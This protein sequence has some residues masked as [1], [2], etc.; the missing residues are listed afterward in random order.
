MFEVIVN[1]IEEGF[2]FL[3]ALVLDFESLHTS[4]YQQESAMRLDK[5]C[6]FLHFSQDLEPNDLGSVQSL[7]LLEQAAAIRPRLKIWERPKA[8]SGWW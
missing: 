8:E 6:D 2:Y 7:L 3:A 1:S 5:S 4:K